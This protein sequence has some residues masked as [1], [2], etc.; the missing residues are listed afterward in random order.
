MEKLALILKGLGLLSGIF[1]LIEFFY[2]DLIWTALAILSSLCFAVGSNIWS[3]LR[4][5]KAEGK[6]K[7]E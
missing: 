5:R 7:G 1:A 2:Q 3:I 4:V 6:E